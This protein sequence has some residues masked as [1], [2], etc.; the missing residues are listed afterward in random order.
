MKGKR[1]Q[2]HIG[3]WLAFLLALVAIAAGALYLL[4]PVWQPGYH[5][6]EDGL[7]DL[8]EESPAAPQAD[9]PAAAAPLD[10][11]TA[12]AAEL[13]AL[14]GVGDAKAAAIVAW[15]AE[16]GPFAA[17]DDLTQVAGISARMVESWRG[18][19]GVG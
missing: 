5:P 8:S 11:N 16:H 4:A 7:P 14:P 6:A 12:T 1:L 10:I 18:L 15:R 9:T 3:A 13:T 19:A 2:E 17:L